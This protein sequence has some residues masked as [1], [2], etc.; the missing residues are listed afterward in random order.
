MRTPP[1]LSFAA[2]LLGT[3]AAAAEPRDLPREGTF[4]DLLRAARALDAR[5]A[6]PSTAGC[7]LRPGAREIRLEASLQPGLR[8][9][10]APLADLDEVLSQDGHAALAAPY[11]LVGPRDAALLLVPLIPVSR[12]L[13]QERLPLFVLT[14][15]GTYFATLDGHPALPALPAR[16]LEAAERARLAAELAPSAPNVVVAVEPGVRLE[17]VVELLGQL[18]SA[19]GQLILATAVAPAEARGLAPATYGASA[20]PRRQA[21]LCSDGTSAGVRTV[22]GLEDRGRSAGAASARAGSGSGQLGAVIGPIG[23][24]PRGGALRGPG[25]GGAGAF[26]SLTAGGA[27][28]GGLGIGGVGGG[29]GLGSGG[30]GGGGGSATGFGFGFGSGAPRARVELGPPQVQGAVDPALVRRVLL[31]RV[32]ALRYCY[33]RERAKAPDLQGAAT[34]RFAVSTAGAV[35][36]PSLA[37]DGMQGAAGDLGPCLTR[38]LLRATFPSPAAEAQVE[39]PL[40]FLPPPAA[41]PAP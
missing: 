41:A 34:L 2:L 30:L 17:P 37:T 25:I 12:L 24:A 28:V 14:D 32:G 29:G 11:G 7:L 3:S 19:G 6:S 35:G 23:T 4:G 1:A 26:G 20:Q 8:P 40:R 9:L 18:S 22:L 33:E 39:V 21:A 16:A 27:G 38:M 31:Q 15:R 13:P 10:P 5:G 36:A